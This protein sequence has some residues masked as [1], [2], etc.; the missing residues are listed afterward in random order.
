MPKEEVAD[1]LHQEMM[2]GDHKI[3]VQ[4]GKEKGH[5]G[6][7]E[8]NVKDL[9][10]VCMRGRAQKKETQCHERTVLRLAVRRVVAATEVDG[11]VPDWVN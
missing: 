5:R 6:V 9:L 8:E 4:G 1:E 7:S 11:Q 2:M 3:L 10:E